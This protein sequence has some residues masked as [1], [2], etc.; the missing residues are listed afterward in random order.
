MPEEHALCRLTDDDAERCEV[1]KGVTRGDRLKGVAERQAVGAIEAPDPGRGS[2]EKP[3]ATQRHHH[4]ERPAESTYA[5]CDVCDSGATDEVD[6]Q[7]EPDDC[8][9]YAAERWTAG[10]VTLHNQQ[11]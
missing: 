5:V 9:Q 10:E 2:N 3:H 7:R 1:A 8:G 4:D 6:K 11:S